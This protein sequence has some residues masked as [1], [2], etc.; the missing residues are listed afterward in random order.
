MHVRA[1]LA[2][3]G[4]QL[5]NWQFRSLW[6]ACR[7]AKERLLGNP[8]LDAEPVVILG[9]GTS[10]IGGT[11]RT[12]L[13]RDEIESILLEGFFPVGEAS[14]Y[15]QR[16]AAGRH[17]RDGPAL[18]VGPGDHTPSGPLSEPA[19]RPGRVQKALSPTRRRCCSTVG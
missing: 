8:D 14:D 7:K 10:L 1:K 19:G 4:T 9:R 13:T 5:D 11:I 2:Q 16:K 6:H 12:E 15:P 3:Q 18:R 17:A